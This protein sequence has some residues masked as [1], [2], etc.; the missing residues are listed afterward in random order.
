MSWQIERF[1][2]AAATDDELRARYALDAEIEGELW[3]EDPVMPFDAWK[4]RILDAPSWNRTARWVAWD[5]GRT[6]VLG[7]SRLAMGFTETNRH[8][9]EVEVSV[10]KAE[11]RGG[12]GRALLV[13]V[14]AEAESEGR[15]LLNGGGPTDGDG[16]AFA[17][18]LGAERKITERKSRMVLAGVDRPMLEG[19]TAKAE[20]RAAGYSLLRWDGPA[21]DEYL[22]KFVALTMVMNT[23]PR[24]DL[25]MD[26]WIHTP[27]RHRE[28]EERA[29]RQGY[30]WWTVVCR[31]DETDELCGFTEFVFPPY[32][33][34]AA[35]QEATAVDPVH[36]DKGIGRWLK[37]ANALRLMDE[38]PEV[39]HVDTWNAFSNAP[40]LGINIAMGF[41]VVKSYTEYQIPTDRLAAALKSF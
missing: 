30:K 22:D 4:H 20:E 12:L 17:E 28:Q 18:A 3:S 33:P 37:A 11:R 40:M 21:P 1:D 36:R 29:L 31:H 34:T 9:G 2:P 8:L 14:V 13:P 27:E 26:D 32:D 19:W 35:W 7:A 38:H 24:D 39:T 23:A 16:N 25:E 15:T 6:R 10:T 41:E 5:A